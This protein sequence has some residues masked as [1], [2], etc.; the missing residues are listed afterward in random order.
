MSDRVLS[1]EASDVEEQ[2]ELSLRPQRLGQY[3]GQ[4]KVKD[5]LKI[6]IEAQHYASDIQNTQA[7]ILLLK[8][9][10][11]IVRRKITK[12]FFSSLICR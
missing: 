11:Q 8:M 2:F 5:N 4:Q 9:H 6:F 12:F 3:I 1:G 10:R 7:V